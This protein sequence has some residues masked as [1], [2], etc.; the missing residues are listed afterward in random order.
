MKEELLT[1][2]F[3]KRIML[4]QVRPKCYECTYTKVSITMWWESR[5]DAGKLV[6]AVFFSLPL[7]FYPPFAFIFIIH[8]PGLLPYLS[9][10][11]FLAPPSAQN[12]R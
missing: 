1:M 10:P 8:F 7:S 5:F 2:G 4:H 6:C 12:V 3:E 9:L 11:P